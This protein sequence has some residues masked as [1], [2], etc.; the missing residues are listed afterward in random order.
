MGYPVPSSAPGMGGGLSDG[1]SPVEACD[2]PTA[3][4][5]GAGVAVARWK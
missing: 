5:K 3:V 4:G 1:K 2:I